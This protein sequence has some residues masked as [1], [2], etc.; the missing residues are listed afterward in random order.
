MDQG[1]FSIYNHC[2]SRIESFDRDIGNLNFILVF[3][4]SSPPLVYFCYC[5]FYYPYYVQLVR[6]G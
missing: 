1:M 3:L 6:E 2:H 5:P 4:V